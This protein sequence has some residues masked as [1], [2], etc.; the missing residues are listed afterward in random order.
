MRRPFSVLND[1]STNQMDG[2]SNSLNLTNQDFYVHMVDEKNKENNRVLACC[3]P[4]PLIVIFLP[5]Y[6]LPCRLQKLQN[7]IQPLIILWPA[8][9]IHTNSTFWVIFEELPFCHFPPPNTSNHGK[10]SQIWLI[11]YL[12]I[13][14]VQTN[15]KQPYSFPVL[16]RF[17]N[18]L[19]QATSVLE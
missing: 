16:S 13:L 9:P 5:F 19:L 3:T 14:V 4:P 18:G 12:N 11:F 8:Y 6:D 7:S 17:C 2:L 1:R 10:D 15:G